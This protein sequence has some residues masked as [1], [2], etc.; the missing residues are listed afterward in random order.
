VPQSPREFSAA[1][2]C[3]RGIFEIV[4]TL[5]SL[6]FRPLVRAA[7]VDG[8]EA[9]AV[10][11]VDGNTL[12]LTGALDGVEARAI[13]AVITSCMRS[14]GVLARMLDGELIES[15]LEERVI[16]I[17]IAARCVFVVAVPNRELNGPQGALNDFRFRVERLISDARADFS[18][19]RS[20]SV[21]SGGSS[22]GPAELPVVEW[23]VTIPRK[24][25]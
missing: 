25:S 18:G 7:V 12:A 5:E 3:S 16:G 2:E 21:G 19:S 17:G 10:L 8:L 11:D 20:P 14:Q 22:S 9:A 13:S 4:K 15:A 23:G 6:D 1:L 24:P